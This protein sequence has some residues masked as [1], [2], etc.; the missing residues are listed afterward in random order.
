[1]IH[2]VTL[3]HK[4]GE[5]II[6]LSEAPTKRQLRQIQTLFS[7]VHDIDVTSHYSHEDRA[8]DP[9]AYINGLKEMWEALNK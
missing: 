9:K 3:N 8:K 5:D 2:V 6:L 7:K 1:M 4:H